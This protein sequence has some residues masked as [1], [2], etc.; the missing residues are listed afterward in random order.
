MIREV[1]RPQHTD[2]HITIPTEYLNREIEFIMFPLD[3]RET[4]PT[5]EKSPIESLGGAFQ[6]YADPAKKVL[7]ENIWEMHVREKYQ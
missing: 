1:I 3:E 4:T 2:F 5:L 7:E 6:Q